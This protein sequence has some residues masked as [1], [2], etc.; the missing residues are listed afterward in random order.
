VPIAVDLET[1][2]RIGARPIRTIDGKTGTEVL[3]H[4][5]GTSS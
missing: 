5:A 3:G 2:A 4:P 1:G